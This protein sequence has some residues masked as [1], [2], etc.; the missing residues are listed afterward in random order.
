M[1]RGALGEDER[2]AAGREGADGG[3]VDDVMCVFVKLSVEVVKLSVEM[4]K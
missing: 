3:H 4:V 2:G 1:E